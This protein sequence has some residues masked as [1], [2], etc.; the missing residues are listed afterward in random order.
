MEYPIRLPGHIK[1]DILMASL[2]LGFTAC[3]D[4]APSS[5]KASEQPDVIVPNQS[6]LPAFNFSPAIGAV[7]LQVFFD[8][9]DT[10]DDADD[11]DNL[12]FRWDF[13]GDG[14]WDTEYTSNIIT[15]YTYVLSGEFSPRL[16][17]LDSEEAVAW[18]AQEG[19]ISAYIE[20]LP[21]GSLVAD[22][23]VDTNRNGAI[24][25][26]DDMNENIFTST[27]GAVY[28]P[29]LDDD[30]NNGERD[31]ID[32]EA[33]P[34][35]EID[36]FSRIHLAQIQGLS[37]EHQVVLEISPQKAADRVRLYQLQSESLELIS[38]LSN[39]TIIIP[40]D[41]IG[42]EGLD[43]LLEGLVG[44]SQYFNGEISLRLVLKEGHDILSQDK[45]IMKASPV[46]FPDNTQ[47]GKRLYIMK[48]TEPSASTNFA[49]YNKVQ[50]N[51]PNSIELY[52]VDEYDYGWDRWVQD[53][54]QTGYVE[55]PGAAGPIR[56]DF[57][58]QVKRETG[59]AGLEA[60]LPT[61]VLAPDTGFIYPG[62]DY[63]TSLNYGGN[64]EIVPPH[65]TMNADYPFGRIVVGGG[66]GGTLEGTVYEDHM[67]TNQRNWLDAQD[68]QGPSI[69][70]SSEWLAVGH[71][72][73]I[74][75]FVP[76]YRPQSARPWKVIIASPTLAWNGL[77]DLYSQNLGHSKVFE[78]RQEQ[79]TV[80]HILTDAELFYYNQAAQARI[81][82]IRIQLEETLGLGDEDFIEL[83]VLYEP[84]WYGGYDFAL[85]Y[86]PG[87]QNLIVADDVLFI[88]DP[89]GP[90]VGGVGLWQTQIKS[91]LESLGFEI[92]F[93]DV[94]E[95]YHVMM[96][97]AHCGSNFEREG[98]TTPWWEY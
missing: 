5:D 95:P 9:S 73:E 1:T 24:D 78:G 17:V 63:E 46:I 39:N 34:L 13:D 74:F 18:T 33:D 49:F 98:F 3:S 83:P 41:V 23:R 50:N 28:M 76:D 6:P 87:V 19:A 14:I 10:T 22:I 68:V 11:L 61:E 35:L 85:A 67:D 16:G 53:S 47:T 91:R 62:G 65:T 31:G 89:E 58:L 93:V 96:G 27:S 54:M 97:E 40:N 94:F 75:L 52:S 36:E 30:D 60:L 86:N 81:D 38:D 90:R 15:D 64:L 84:L 43:L 32:N 56:Y 77:T 66:D 26:A 69:E 88:P 70:L 21:P 44:R 42:E 2:L 7:P 51:L 71:L 57:H 4:G 20:G 8:A 72:D 12:L 59:D 25:D 92:H 48:I 55:S 82:S 79:T 80:S 45:A 37:P 29:N